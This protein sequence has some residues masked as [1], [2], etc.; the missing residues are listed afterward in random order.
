[1]STAH[2]TGRTGTFTTFTWNSSST[3]YYT[4]HSQ[5]PQ[6]QG[7]HPLTGPIFGVITILMVVFGA[8]AN[9]VSFMYFMKK[10]GSNAS[11]TIYRLM[12]MVDL[13]ICLLL[14]PIGINYFN[15]H[16]KETPYIFNVNALCNIWSICWHMC[17]RLSICLI[18]VMSTARA[19]SLVKP[20]YFLR[21]K[22]IIVPFTVYTFFLLIQQTLP[23]WFRS[24]SDLPVVR[25]FNIMGICSWTFADI[26]PIFSW[27]HK[28]CD[29]FFIQLEFLFPVVPIIVSSVVSIAKLLAKKEPDQPRATNKNRKH[30]TTTIIIL[31]VVFVLLNAP[32]LLYQ[33]IASVA[34]YS[35]GTIQLQWDS[36]MPINAR[37]VLAHIY[38]IHLIGL[39]SCIN[40][41]I[42]FIRIKELRLHV[43]SPNTWRNGAISRQ[44][45]V[46]KH[47][48]RVVKTASRCQMV[49]RETTVCEDGNY[50][51]QITSTNGA[52]RVE[53]GYKLLTDAVE[54]TIC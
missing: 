24:R 22:A 15:P 20:L 26:A 45:V 9:I 30:A 19:I 47:S 46:H 5:R 25:Y 51:A 37:K 14:V 16:R 43:L 50:E 31:S 28:V 36:S 41:I 23:Y 42:Y 8:P 29:F 39:N 13:F 40:P 18:G 33:L 54:E 53:N 35:N 52:V 34:T 4:T 10:S 3:W 6:P 12:N 21:R 1:M 7:I 49:R 38:N 11:T 2:V 32:F 27:G 48:I 17:G 44:S